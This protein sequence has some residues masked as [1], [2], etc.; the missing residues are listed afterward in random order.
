MDD[1]KSPTNFMN[2]E[3]NKSE[4]NFPMNPFTRRSSI[5]IN[6]I[7]KGNE[8]SFNFQSYLDNEAKQINE[9]SPRSLLISNSKIK[10]K[11]AEPPQ[12]K[13]KGGS[14]KNAYINKIKHLKKNLKI[15]HDEVEKKYFSCFSSFLFQNKIIKIEKF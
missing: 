13:L 1:V 14:F 8:E 11:E 12:T 6:N 9:F 7:G 2:Q 15:K 10:Q 5:E 4:K 3:S